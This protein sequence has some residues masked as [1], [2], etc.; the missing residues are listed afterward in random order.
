MTLLER[1]KPTSALAENGLSEIKF[2]EHDFSK[3]TTIENSN[4]VV[5]RI[6]QQFA[7]PLSTSKLIAELAGFGGVR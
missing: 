1:R 7:L 6:A 5:W 3:S 2:R 4:L